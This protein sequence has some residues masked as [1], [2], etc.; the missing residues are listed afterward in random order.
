[1]NG[2]RAPVDASCTACGAQPVLGWEG[3]R[4][5]PGG[6]P[7]DLPIW[8]CRCGATVGCHKGTTVALG[9][10]ADAGTR[11]ARQKLH[12]LLDPLW[13]DAPFRPSNAARLQAAEA[14][15]R[16]TAEEA[17]VRRE[18]RNATYRLLAAGLGIDA[19]HCHVAM[20]DL[21]RCRAAW[22]VLRSADHPGAE[23]PAGAARPDG[24]GKEGAEWGCSTT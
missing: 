3:R 9:R 12:A 7:V 21:G 23:T 22:R 16:R 10:P 14:C 11:S 2:P 17:A 15:G 13:R 18:A 20:F 1:M 24:E 4:A 5:G 19:A 8:R 6:A